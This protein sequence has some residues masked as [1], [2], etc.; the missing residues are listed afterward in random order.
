M[1]DTGL[2]KY[3]PNAFESFSLLKSDRS[4][5]GVQEHLR[6]VQLSCRKNKFIQHLSSDPLPAEPS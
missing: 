2:K 6:Q 4:F 3:R 1:L 5:L